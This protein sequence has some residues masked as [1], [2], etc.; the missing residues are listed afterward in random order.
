MNIL[1]EKV[2]HI[3]FGTGVVMQIDDNRICVQF[4]DSV[5]IKM[6]IYPDAFEKF[7]KA[8]D[9]TVQINAMED[10]RKKKEQID[11][12]VIKLE[13]EREAAELQERKTKLTL[14]SKKISGKA[15]KKKPAS[16]E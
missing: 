14:K 9:P 7:L 16:K 2:E 10:W 12:A 15:A 6:F 8:E 13:K 3:K 11:M 4:Q 1:N 5:G